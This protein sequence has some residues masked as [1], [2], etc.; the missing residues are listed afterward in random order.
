MRK[1]FSAFVSHLQIW[2]AV[3]IVAGAAACSGESSRST[4]TSPTAGAAAP[5]PSATGATITGT[6]NAGLSTSAFATSAA[7]M[8]IAVDGTAL[9]TTTDGSGAFTLSGVP[10]GK[11]TLHFM[12]TSADAR[13]DIN[14]VTEHETI[15]L[16]VRVNGSQVEVDD[17]KGE[18]P[19][20]H[21][22]IEGRVTD[23]NVA[24]RT[25]TVN[26]ITITVPDGTT[27][28]HGSTTIA[29][30]KD[31]LGD[32][33][34]VKATSTGPMTASAQ[35]IMVQTDHGNPGGGD[36]NDNEVELTG[37]VSGKAGAC[38][39]SVT[40]TFKLGTTQV[41]TNGS[42]KFEDTTCATLANGD[43]VEVNGTRQSATAI[44]ATKVSKED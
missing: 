22:E 44:L 23:V 43:R 6:V 4:P 36:E 31:L 2:S 41:T 3:L 35:E 27:I 33:V 34:H 16:H 10:T 11:I 9:S 40:M 20:H 21:L 28:R 5:A 29:F 32:Q 13:L 8:T 15:E 18:T 14:D 24:G 26:N 39:P 38:T 1:Q 37:T 30:T 25:L 19:D 17:Q 12:G 7:G 42:T